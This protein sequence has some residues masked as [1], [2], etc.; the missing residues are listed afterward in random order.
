M[1]R[2]SENLSREQ[3]GQR[4]CKSVEITTRALFPDCVARLG[5]QRACYREL[6]A[7][8]HVGFVENGR[9]A[10]CRYYFRGETFERS[11]PVSA[12]FRSPFAFFYPKNESIIGG[13]KKQN[14]E[15]SFLR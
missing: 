4:G 2:M 9:A 11:G 15:D 8:R 5:E 14:A 12:L 3:W 6:V 1:E 10:R 13:G 7:F